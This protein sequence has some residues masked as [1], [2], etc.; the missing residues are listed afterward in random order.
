MK[1]RQHNGLACVVK[2]VHICKPLDLS[3][4]LPKVEAVEDGA[5]ALLESLEGEHET[6]EIE[7]MSGSHRLT[8][9]SVQLQRWHI[10]PKTPTK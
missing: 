8:F 5:Q 9:G 1:P 3:Y 6:A 10:S 4:A 2:I 7:V